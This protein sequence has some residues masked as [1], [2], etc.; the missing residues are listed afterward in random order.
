MWGSGG[1]IACAEGSPQRRQDSK[2]ELGAY[3]AVAGRSRPSDDPS[4]PLPDEGLLREDEGLRC[5]VVGA[6]AWLDRLG[7]GRLC[8]SGLAWLR[9]VAGRLLAGRFVRG[10][11]LEGARASRG[12]SSRETRAGGSGAR[13]CGI[14]QYGQTIQRGSIGLSQFSHGSLTL[15]RQFGQR[16]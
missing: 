9:A 6:W 15:A 8:V 7:R 5:L 1:A 3:D 12:R 11:G 2:W 14:S 4:R 16:R 13:R 10:A